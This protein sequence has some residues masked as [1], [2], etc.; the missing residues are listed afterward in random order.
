MTRYTD[1]KAARY[2]NK[3]LTGVEPER[4]RALENAWSDT[5]G[6]WFVCDA[7]RAYRLESEPDGLRVVLHERMLNA[8]QRAEVERVHIAVES[9]FDA[10][11][12]GAT[13][14]IPVDYDAVVAASR[15]READY[16]IDLGEDFP[17]VNARYLRDAMELLPGGRVCCQDN[18][19]RMISPVYVMSPDGIALILPVRRENK[20]HWV[21]SRRSA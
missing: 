3:V 4:A 12:I 2:C 16:T 8:A 1:K 15:D 5:F 13:V 19:R 18:A 14:E 21:Y 11:R 9:M 6:R 7:Y 10:E 17:V 20:L